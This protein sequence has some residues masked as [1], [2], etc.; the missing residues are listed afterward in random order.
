M[1]GW[2][3]VL[4]AAFL[5]RCGAVGCGWLWCWV[6]LGGA[7][8]WWLLAAAVVRPCVVCVLVVVARWRAGVATTAGR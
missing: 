7:A 1:L 4:L 5:A 3:A 2:A 6:V 8:W